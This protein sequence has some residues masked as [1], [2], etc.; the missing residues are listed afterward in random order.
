MIKWIRS[1]IP[2]II[3]KSKYN[4]VLSVY[5]LIGF[6]HCCF[7]NGLLHEKAVEELEKLRPNT[8]DQDRINKIK[9]ILESKDA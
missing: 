3:T 5:F 4:Q 2:F 9:N 8:W 6:N 7:I 1:H